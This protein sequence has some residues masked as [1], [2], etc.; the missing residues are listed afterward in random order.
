MSITSVV[1]EFT[2]LYS[3]RILQK[4]KRWQDGVL[5]FYEHNHKVEIHDE[6]QRHIVLSD[7]ME[8]RTALL[9]PGSQFKLTNKNWLV[10]VLDE[11]PL[12]SRIL[13][14]SGA[15]LALVD[16]VKGDT[17]IKRE[18]S[19][20]PVNSRMEATIKVYPNIKK[21]Q[22]PLIKRE[23]QSHI[24]ETE[25]IKRES[26]QS[27]NIPRKSDHIQS[28]REPRI[29]IK[30]EDSKWPKIDALARPRK[31]GLTRVKKRKVNEN[32]VP[33]DTHQPN[34]S[35][36][37]ST[38]R[39]VQDGIMKGNAN[40]N[41]ANDNVHAKTDSKVNSNTNG[42]AINSHTNVDTNGT[43]VNSRTI[44]DTNGTSVNSHNNDD[45]NNTTVSYGD[46]MFPTATHSTTNIT[47]TSSQMINHTNT[48]HILKVSHDFESNF[49]IPHKPFKLRPL[50]RIPP[51]SS[52][53]FSNISTL[54]ESS[55]LLYKEAPQKPKVPVLK[56][57]YNESHEYDLSS[58]SEVE[59]I[60]EE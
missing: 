1:R 48:S 56:E 16:I 12:Y 45:T 2:V 29:H 34:V 44:V 58:N 9:K 54:C 60:D 26:I 47:Q 36:K 14:K 24:T 11:R 7:F 57:A 17:D 6:E 37:V 19:N 52:T 40:E 25:Y 15:G 51:H 46:D 31:V 10:D 5:K 4:D 41:V 53:Y 30:K 3:N 18:H 49:S 33:I 28:Q 43:T 55:Q 23:P 42:A 27:E 35:G 22:E 50:P 59:D 13:S 39:N 38:S 21:E 8:G 32:L 20:K